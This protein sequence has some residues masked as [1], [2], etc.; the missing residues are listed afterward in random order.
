MSIRHKI[1]FIGAIL[2]LPIT[3]PAYSNASTFFS[4]N[5]ESPSS[6]GNW[7]I[8]SNGGS[9]QLVEGVMIISAPRGYTY[10]YLYPTDFLIPQDNY[11]ISARIKLEGPLSFGFGL[12][13]TDRLL[14]NGRTQDLGGNERIFLVWPSTDGT[15]FITAQPCPIDIEDCPFDNY[16]KPI[17]ST[18]L[19]QWMD[20]D[21]ISKLNR[22]YVY[23]DKELIYTSGLSDLV[24]STFW[25]GNP[26][27]TNQIQTWGRISI[28]RILFDDNFNLLNNKTKIILTPGFG[29]SWDYHALLSGEGGSDWHIP[30]WITL[31]NNLITSLENTGY[32][33]DQ[34]L[35]IFPY[36]WRKNLTSLRFDLEN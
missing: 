24:I 23:V 30:S 1:I 31:Y 8:H 27:R 29:A 34:D 21:I 2:F 17:H 22:Y 9:V 26:Q 20:L 18:Q 6:L 12:N 36:D 13:L 33:Y 16:R 7:T 19:G 28:D 10:P 4:D 5:F 32:A 35:F 11:H 25:V 15:Y 14:P 3:A